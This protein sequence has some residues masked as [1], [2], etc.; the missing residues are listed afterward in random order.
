MCGAVGLLNVDAIAVQEL[1]RLARKGTAQRGARDERHLV[2][3]SGLDVG[4]QD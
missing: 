1:L 4:R 2:A 3:L